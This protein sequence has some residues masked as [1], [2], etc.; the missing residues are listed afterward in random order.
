MKVVAGMNQ[1]QKQLRQ[2]RLESPAESQL[3]MCG[4]N[5]AVAED[6]DEVFIV[7]PPT[8][9]SRRNSATMHFHKCDN[10]LCSLDRK[11]SFSKAS[12]PANS[13]SSYVTEKR[14]QV[15]RYD[16]GAAVPAHIR[17]RFRLDSPSIDYTS[18]NVQQQQ[19]QEQ[20]LK[21]PRASSV[22]TLLTSSY[23]F[24]KSK[25]PFTYIETTS[26]KKQQQLAAPRVRVIR[27]PLKVI[28]VRQVDQRS[29][30]SH[31]SPSSNHHH[32]HG[33]QTH[34]TVLF[35]RLSCSPNRRTNNDCFIDESNRRNVIDN[36]FLQCYFVASSTHH[37]LLSL[38]F[39]FFFFCFKALFIHY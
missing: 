13:L 30:P 37:L 18:S 8:N 3:T 34:K 12:S 23:D 9:N 7:S 36:Y 28:R 14:F 26:I 25:S 20:M 11:S 32:N 15:N 38:N 27:S 10:R 2:Q 35:T 22:N 33:K 31:R 1:Q 21:R 19:Q 17:F 5:D 24:Q 39:L 29:S 4:L 6:E 16:P